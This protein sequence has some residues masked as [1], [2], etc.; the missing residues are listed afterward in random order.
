MTNEWFFHFFHF[1]FVFVFV[2][3]I[4]WREHITA[5][6]QRPKKF[7]DSFISG[8]HEFQHKEIRGINEMKRNHIIEK[9]GGLMGAKRTEFF[10]KM[11]SNAKLDD[12]CDTRWS[13]KIYDNDM[14]LQAFRLWLPYSWR[15]YRDLIGS[16]EFLY[17]FE[18]LM[19][20]VQQQG[21]VHILR[22]QDFQIFDPP[23][24]PPS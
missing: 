7:K 23:P 12:L 15:W 11:Q 24:P 16:W 17:N 5:Q 19:R 4:F 3:S 22:Q 13:S 18:L 9:L 14:E 8:T 6:N 1:Y 10:R 20:I 2:L 21:N